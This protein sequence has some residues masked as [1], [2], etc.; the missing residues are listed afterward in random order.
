M[1]TGFKNVT[2]DQAST[3]KLTSTKSDAR[4]S[5]IEKILGKRTSRQSVASK[6][7]DLDSIVTKV[8]TEDANPDMITFDKPAKK[9]RDPSELPKSLVERFDDV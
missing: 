1:L 7:D 8:V 3:E 5:F 6:K 4:P 2:I 9:R